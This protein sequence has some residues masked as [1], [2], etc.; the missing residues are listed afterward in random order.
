[1]HANI[2]SAFCRGTER[3]LS[4]I[5]QI[6]PARGAAKTQIMHTER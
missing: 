4:N 2:D 6:T 1:M 5:S 3:K